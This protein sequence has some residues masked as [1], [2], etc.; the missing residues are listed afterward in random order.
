[1]TRAGKQIVNKKKRKYRVD[2]LRVLL[3]VSLVYFSITFIKQQ[4][5]INEYNVK[6]NSIKEDIV[7][8]KEEI[9][10]LKETKQKANDSEYIERVA[11]EELGLVKPY[12]KVFIDVSK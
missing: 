7:S 1:M 9:Q 4:F 11:R 5:E 10:V 8:A 2:Y 3:I 12:E 6:I